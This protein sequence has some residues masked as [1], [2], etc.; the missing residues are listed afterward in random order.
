M[1]KTIKKML[2][3]TA[4]AAL[5]LS[6]GSM[7]LIGCG[8]GAKDYTF[9]AEHAVWSDGI[10]IDTGAVWGQEGSEA[11]FAGNFNQAG[12]TISWTIKASKECDA[13][14]TLHAA[15]ASMGMTMIDPNGNPMD[16]T[17]YKVSLAEVDMSTDQITISVNDTAASMTG[18]LP[19]SPAEWD[20]Q[21]AEGWHNVGTATGTIHLKK[22]ENVI[23][24]EITG[25]PFQGY[26]TAGINT[27]KIVINSEAKLTFTKTD[28]SDKVNNPSQGG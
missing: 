16:Q 2:G 25:A 27:D 11:T 6:M 18:K 26:W 23:T 7:A 10:Y 28:N 14:L 17:N 4:A 15:S 8:G 19:G 3:I 5:T 21:S 20:G 22:G 13:T 24:L 12:Q 1:K 9:E